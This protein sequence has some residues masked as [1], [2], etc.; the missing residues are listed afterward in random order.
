M[1]NQI[2]AD[3]PASTL[4][5]ESQSLIENVVWKLGSPNNNNSSFDSNWNDSTSGV[6]ASISYT[7]ERANTNGKI[8]SGGSFCNDTVTRTNTWTGKVGLFYSSDYLYATSGGNAANRTT[9]LNKPMYYWNIES[10]LS[11][12]WLYNGQSQWILSPFTSTECSNSVFAVLSN[13]NIN[14]FAA[15]ERIAIYPTVYLKSSV[16]I[17]GGEGTQANPYTLQ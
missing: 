12:D 1:G 8:C 5:N 9:C 11:N 16:G 10:C 15:Y 3:M 7:R 4:S 6:T 2:S 14:N 13:G 17:T